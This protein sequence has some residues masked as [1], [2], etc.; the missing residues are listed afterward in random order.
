MARGRMISRTLGTS[1]KKFARLRE[2]HQEIGLFAQALYPLLVANADDFGRMDGDAFSVKHAVWSTAP[3]SEDQFDAALDAMAAERLITRY[4]DDSGI[5]AE[6]VDFERHQVGLHKRTESRFPA[7][8]GSVQTIPGNS[9]SREE[10]RTEQ[11][12]TEEKREARDLRGSQEDPPRKPPAGRSD[13]ALAGE[14]PKDFLTAVYVSD[15]FRWFVP[16]AVHAKFKRALGGD[17]AHARLMHFY[18]EAASRLTEADVQGDA[19]RFWQPLFDA[20]FVAPK[21]AKPDPIGRAV[22]GVEATR[23][24]QD[25]YEARRAADPP[26]KTLAEY[27]ADAAARKAAQRVTQP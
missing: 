25:S 20:K 14:L 18:A 16:P 13:G 27:V 21:P 10:K 8:S 6:I 26:T 1:S 7:P 15:N 22:P 23:Q 19:F 4:R 5:Y 9:G 12:G 17:D 3:E 24:L 2:R 11:K